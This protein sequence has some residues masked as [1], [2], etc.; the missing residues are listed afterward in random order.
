MRVQRV[1]EPPSARRR[2]PGRASPGCCAER[3]ATPNQL[4][5]LRCHVYWFKTDYS[6]VDRSAGVTG[7]HRARPAAARRAAPAQRPQAAAPPPRTRRPRA[8]LPHPPLSPYLRDLGHPAGRPRT[9]RPA[10]AR[11]RRPR[12]GAPLHRQLPRRGRRPPPGLRSAT[13]TRRRREAPGGV[14]VAVLAA[15]GVEEHPLAV[16]GAVAIAPAPGDL[17]VGLVQ[18]PGAAGLAAAASLAAGPRA[19]WRS[20]PPRRGSSRA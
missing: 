8:P 12:D 1:A 4:I 5:A 10:L 3:G 7:R 15:H 14:L 18:V 16:D 11:P 9:R 13:S 2:Q 6:R 17:H 20:G 19:A